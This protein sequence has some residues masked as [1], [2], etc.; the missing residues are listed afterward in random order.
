MASQSQNPQERRQAFEV[1]VRS[2]WKPVYKTIRI[3][4]RKTNEDA[5]D[6]TQ[7]FFSAAIEKNFF[8]GFDPQKARFRTY[9]RTCLDRYLA[10]E[11]KA[12]QRIKRGGD[13]KILALDFDSAENELKFSDLPDSQSIEDYFD[14]EW[15]RS[16]F[17]IAVENLRKECES[18]SKS[19]HFKIFE[20]YD[21]EAHSSDK[22]TYENLAFEFN[23][24]VTKVTNYLAFARRE[25][26]RL[27][28]ENLRE[29]TLTE[30]EF[31]SEAKSLLGIDL[32]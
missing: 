30:E 24:P 32:K 8:R 18:T 2:Y 17:S 26:R 10:N 31:R 9:L 4:W 14:K 23:L 6:L 28:L 29:I 16:L 21:L 7:G 5:K 11:Q 19:V 1:L 13:K 15:V 25:F 12:A 20:R 27:L 3:K 22:S